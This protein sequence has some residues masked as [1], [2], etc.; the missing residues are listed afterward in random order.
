MKQHKSIW[1]KFPA[2]G[3]APKLV[4]DGGDLLIDLANLGHSLLGLKGWI[5]RVSDAAHDAHEL[6]H[7]TRGV[8][9]SG[10]VQE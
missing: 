10:W 6:F 8:G 5:C 1:S 3:S 2:P 4:R 7:E 9:G